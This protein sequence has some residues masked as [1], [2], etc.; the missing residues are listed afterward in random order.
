M[1]Q[2]GFIKM[3]RAITE[4]EWYKDANTSRLFIHFVCTVNFTPSKWRGITIERGQRVTSHNKLASEL[5]I[6][7]Q[8]IRT[9]IKHLISTGEITYQSTSQYGIV[10]V[11]NYEKFQGLTDHLTVGQQSAN[12]QLTVDQQQYNK[13]NNNNKDLMSEKGV[14]TLVGSSDFSSPKKTKE[15]RE[16]L[17]GCK[18]RDLCDLLM[19]RMRENNPNCRLPKDNWKWCESFRLMMERD[20]RDFD[21][22]KSIIGFSQWDNFWKTVILSADKLRDKYDQLTLRR[23]E[24]KRQYG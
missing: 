5:D 21:D 13:D 18:E 17:E 2:I 15:K 8:G 24:V 4:W 9:A 7:I 3:Y 23:D 6:S 10:T 16:Y 20:G 19:N 14:L 1:E 11:L 22:I 12:S